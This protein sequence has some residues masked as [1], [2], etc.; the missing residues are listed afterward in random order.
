MK[1]EVVQKLEAP[2]ARPVEGSGPSSG[3]ACT[4]LVVSSSIV[5]DSATPW[6]VIC[7]APVSTRILQAR[8]QEWVATPFSRR[9][10]R[11]RDQTWISCVA[12]SLLSESPGKPKSCHLFNGHRVF[13]PWFIH[14]P[15]DGHTRDIVQ[16]STMN[17]LGHMSFLEP[18]I[19]WGVGKPRI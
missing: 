19:S 15:A 7:Q 14:S 6:T 3:F 9:S 10:Y 11:P 17:I 2:G 13:Q 1:A 16:A 4:V 12:G 5:S 18:C 8:T